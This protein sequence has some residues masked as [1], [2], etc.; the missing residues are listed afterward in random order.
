MDWLCALVLN[1][2]FNRFWAN[3]NFSS[4]SLL[5]A[6]S[7]FCNY[8]LEALMCGNKGV[9][10]W[11]QNLWTVG[12]IRYAGCSKRYGLGD[13]IY[14]CT[15]QTSS[16][17]VGIYI[18]CGGY[19]CTARWQYIYSTVNLYVQYVGYVDIYQDRCMCLIY[20]LI[21]QL[22][23][24]LKAERVLH[25]PGSCIILQSTSQYSLSDCRS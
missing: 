11:E 13:R 15:A 17:L 1:G 21:L 19:I 23:E 6:F 4:T 25:F 9:N 2:L 18:H 14:A 3:P 7:F 12:R 20:L 16:C 8:R 10:P 22:F 5:S 24:K